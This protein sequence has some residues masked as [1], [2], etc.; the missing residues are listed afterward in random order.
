MLVARRGAARDPARRLAL[1]LAGLAAAHVPLLMVDAPAALAAA[2]VLAGLG[3]APAMASANG[4]IDGVAPAGTITE[5]FTW[6]S[7]GIA[8]GLAAGGPLAGAL[9]EAIGPASG[10]LPAAAACG[11]AAAIVW[12]WR[13][14]LRP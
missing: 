4:S 6:L 14:T 9:A 5:A 8:A 2:L 12:R 1:L 10:F 11:L 13:A 3:V 7:T